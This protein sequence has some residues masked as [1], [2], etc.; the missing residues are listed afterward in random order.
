MQFIEFGTEERDASDVML[1]RAERRLFNAKR[2][3]NRLQKKMGK[4]VSTQPLPQRVTRQGSAQAAANSALV[5]A[6]LAKASSQNQTL[7]AQPVGSNNAAAVNVTPV[8]QP[9]TVP[10][11]SSS[12]QAM[13]RQLRSS[14]RDAVHTV[15]LANPFGKWCY[16]NAVLQAI[17][18][19]PS[20][21]TLL[22]A[23][24]TAGDAGDGVINALL[25]LARLSPVQP[26]QSDSA[27]RFLELCA[28]AEISPVFEQFLVQEPQLQEQQDAAEFVTNLLD[29]LSNTGRPA[30]YRDVGLLFQCSE[31]SVMQCLDCGF[32]SMKGPDPVCMLQIET[33]GCMDSVAPSILELISAF[34]SGSEVVKNCSRCRVSNKPHSKEIF[35]ATLPQVLAIQLKRT[36]LDR[37]ADK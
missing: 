17:M 1:L 14:A 4:A 8:I 30:G 25:A 16:A 15:P 31:L 10:S 11:S 3:L 24:K 13:P 18:N 6:A 23:A 26:A 19:N 32:R 37:N 21:R 12:S 20:V 22:L 34:F 5:A 9:T 7:S 29:Y 27:L 33:R 36:Y 35:L 28:A 2:D